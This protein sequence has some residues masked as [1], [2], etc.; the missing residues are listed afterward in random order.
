MF[1]ARKTM[2]SPQVT[3]QFSAK[4]KPKVFGKAWLGVPLIFD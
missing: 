4:F 1:F 3:C 2:L